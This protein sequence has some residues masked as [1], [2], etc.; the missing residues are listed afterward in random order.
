MK[1]EHIIWDWNGTLIN[2]AWL[3]LTIMNECLTKR[4][5][6]PLSQERYEEIFTIPVEEYYHALGFDFETESFEQAGLEFMMNYN[7][8]NT[9]AELQ[10]DA[11][12]LI[13]HIS[14]S[15]ASQSI[16]SAYHQKDLSALVQHYEIDHQ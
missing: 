10:E 3:C 12:A 16:L 2:D 1:Y 11:I 15:T 5:L 9:E 14:D 4:S 7:A 8:R 6:P 13:H